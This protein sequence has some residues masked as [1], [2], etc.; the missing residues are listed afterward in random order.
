MATNFGFNIG[1]GGIADL[2]Q[3][4]KVTPVRGMQFAP[5]PR[6]PREQEKDSKK[7]LLG[8]LLGS[9]SPFLGD[10]ALKGIAQIPGA[11]KFS[12]KTTLLL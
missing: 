4:P 9:A 12:T 6:L 1:G 3:T 10:L 11:E 5:T 7:Q 8:A 2:V